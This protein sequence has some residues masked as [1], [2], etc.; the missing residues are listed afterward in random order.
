MAHLTIEFLKLVSNITGPI[1]GVCLR[2]ISV[3]FPTGEAGSL[4]KQSMLF[5]PATSEL[6]APAMN[7]AISIVAV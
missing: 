4:G 5:P 7:P 1:S 6:R 2:F 3:K